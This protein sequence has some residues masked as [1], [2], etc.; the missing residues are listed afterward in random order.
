MSSMERAPLGVKI[1]NR[2][3]PLVLVKL[4]GFRHDVLF[5]SDF[6]RSMN[7]SWMIYETSI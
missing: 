4:H 7:E 2:N 3:A 6:R 5:M 1:V